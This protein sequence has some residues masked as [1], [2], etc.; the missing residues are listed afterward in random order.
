MCKYFTEQHS[1]FYIIKKISAFCI[2]NSMLG[3]QLTDVTQYILKLDYS[4]QMKFTSSLS[5]VPLI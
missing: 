5:L 2:I 3:T 4:Y 1:L